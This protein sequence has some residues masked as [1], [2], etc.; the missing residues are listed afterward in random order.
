LIVVSSPDTDRP[1]FFVRTT[2]YSTNIVDTP[3]AR[4]LTFEVNDSVEHHRGINTTE[5]DLMHVTVTGSTNGVAAKFDMSGLATGQRGRLTSS[6]VVIDDYTK[7]FTAHNLT[8]TIDWP[9]KAGTV[10]HGLC[11]GSFTANAAK[12]EHD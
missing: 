10:Q 9:D 2:M 12:I 7:T 11:Q 4:A 3:L 8:G 1:Q 5:Y 6:G